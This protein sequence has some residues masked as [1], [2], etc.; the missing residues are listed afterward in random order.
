[1]KRRS[2]TG[3]DLRDSAP[4]VL[5]AG[6]GNA[7]L[8]AAIAARE[9]GASV[10]LL[11]CA[12]RDFRGGNSRHTRNLRY[13]HENSD[14]VTTGR[15]PEEEFWDDLKRVTGGQTNEAL[16][17]LTIRA[18]ADLGGWMY[19]HGVRFQPPLSGTLH[20]GRTNAFFLGG[21]KA[22]VNAYYRAA[23][24]LGVAIA[25]QAEVDELELR[26]G[27]FASATAR[28]RGER[29]QVKARTFVAASGGFE[30]NIAWLRESWGEAADNFIVRGTPY[31][32][33]R[34]LR[35]LLDSGMQ[36]VGDARQCHAIAVDGRAPKFDGGIV[37]RVDA[38]PFGIVV[39]RG[40]A[41][42]YDEGE[43]FWP[44][45]YA[46]W[47]RLIAQQPG[48]VA[49]AIIDSKPVGKFMPTV[50]PPVT[51]DS[52]GQLARALGLDPAA[53]ERTVRSYNESVRAGTFDPAALDG[54]RT[55]GLQPPKSHWALPIDRPPFSGYL[56]RPGIT[57]TYLGVGV[58]ESARV[59]VRGGERSDN[60]FAAG[61]IMAGN[62][63]GQGYLA[64]LGM[65]IGS[66]FG[67]I[68]GREA[69]ARA[70]R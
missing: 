50:F 38:V 14:T 5:V 35:A 29:V 57:F 58:D 6:G 8:C 40:G 13:V 16:A 52:I 51:A 44:K 25:Y 49:Y 68:A 47:G 19:R 45:R 61:E 11:E 31:N 39:N 32:Q 20:L 17:R 37:T 55:E 28:Y 34:V 43:D 12:P 48:Q 42:F 69:A 53:L 67:R 21:G 9:G 26:D 46:I 7:A 18:S 1:M 22:L 63:L 66:V 30:A 41:R 33:G 3:S 23:E 62:V 36:Q 2:L 56:L 65:T 15:Y 4:D 70:A 59:L 64:G 27:H 54:C 24:D 10:L 60:V